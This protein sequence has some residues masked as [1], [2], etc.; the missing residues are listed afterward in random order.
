MRILVVGAY[1]LIGG[2]VT[3]RLL[4]EKH[5]VVGLGRDVAIA[6]RRFP[7]ARW[8]AADLRT[9][10]TAK[11]E[12]LL[13]GVDAVVNCAG[14]LQD[15][16]RDDLEAVHQRAVSALAQACRAKG[17]RR[18]VHISAL[19]VESGRDR[20]RQTKRAADEALRS[21][22]LEWVILRPAVVLAP[23][24][25]G[26]S[27]LLRGLAAFPG[28]IPV[29]NPGTV[30]QT[31]D[32]ED[33]AE[34]VVRSIRLDGPARFACDLTASEPTRMQDILVALRGWLGIPHATVIALP[35]WIGRLGAALAD[36]IAALG[37]RSPMRSAALAQL[38]AGVQGRS[39]D[40]MEQLGFCPREL[41]ECLT[42]R[43]SGVQER[44]YASL[45][46]LKPLVIV[47]LAAFWAI[48]G[49]VG[50][51][52][53]AAAVR[54]LTDVEMSRTAAETFVLAG[55]AADLGLAVLVVFR[56][57]APL[58]LNGMV[59]LTVGYL[60]GGTFW[61]PHLWSDPLGPL[62][63]SIPA[64]ALALVALAMMDER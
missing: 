28:F 10:T 42:R 54:L 35:R 30:I 37:W 19:G 17:V 16:P 60:A 20:F 64:A 32:V 47:I 62:V 52:S 53:Q 26:G 50:F 40:A 1:G 36:G 12:P 23:A 58:A 3:A 38:S 31:V 24:A 6:K 61:L 59:L 21:T 9:M 34:A 8:V 18:F 43:P 33:I 41:A 11:W 46:F 4:A 29:L 15:S 14:A 55:S 7:A 45:Y 27:A 57:S 48:S 56:R 49:I 51:V 63:K 39:S 25:Y 22:D 2:Y 13:A 44:W 5:S